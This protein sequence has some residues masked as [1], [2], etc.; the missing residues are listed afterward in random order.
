M[1]ILILESVSQNGVE[2]LLLLQAKISISKSSNDVDTLNKNWRNVTEG[3]NESIESYNTRV[4][5]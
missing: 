2:I 5:A 1:M 3:V 4:Q